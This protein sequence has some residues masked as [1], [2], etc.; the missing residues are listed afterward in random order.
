MPAYPA[1]GTPLPFE[2]ALN[3]RELGGY[4]A[5]GGR[6]VRHGLLW[7]GANLDAITSDADR[8]LYASLGIRYI[9]DLR[10]AIETAKHPDLVLPGTRYERICAMR[11]L[12]GQEIDFS[13]AGMAKMAGERDQVAA[14]LGHY[15]S[16]F[17]MFRALYGRMPFDN[18]AF[19]ALFRAM[20]AGET[21]L[22]FHC[23]AG[24][25][26]TGVGAM[27][28]LLA[29][30]ASRE[31]AL[32]DYMQTNVC[33]KPAIEAFLAAHADELKTDADRVRLESMEGVVLPMAEYTLDAIE[34]R[35]PSY[36]AYFEAQYG[37][38]AARLTALRERYLE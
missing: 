20:E 12:D 28:V 22:L 27:L 18:P 14:E 37:L 5:A 2:K 30:G 31:T 11:F 29:L 25:D 17:E 36:E 1:P 32:R 34:A 19:R 4:P 15:P 13:P 7:R 24:K 38:D 3:F 35:Y 8:A 23:S 9:L 16:E 26:R 6:T 33:R 21:P 10:A